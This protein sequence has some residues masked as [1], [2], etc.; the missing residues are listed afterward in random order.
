MSLLLVLQGVL[1]LAEVEVLSSS[2]LE[3]IKNILK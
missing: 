1:D 3:D 2:S